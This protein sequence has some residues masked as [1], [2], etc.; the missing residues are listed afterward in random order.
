MARPTNEKP[1]LTTFCRGNNTIQAVYIRYNYK[2]VRHQGIRVADVSIDPTH[3]GKDGFVKTGNPD[4]QQHNRLIEETIDHIT[5]AHNT[6]VAKG[7]DF[8][9]VSLAA[10]VAKLQD[11]TRAAKAAAVAEEAEIARKQRFDSTLDSAIGIVEV[12]SIPDDENA[13]EKLERELAKKK[14]ELSALKKK[15]NIHKGDQLTVWLHN[16]MKRN[17]EGTT[18]SAST[19]R[20]N[21]SFINTVALFDKDA[22]IGDVDDQ[23]LLKFQQWMNTTPSITPIYKSIVNPATGKRENG[24]LLRYNTGRVRSNDTVENYVTKIKSMLNYYDAYSDLLPEGVTINQKYKRYKF[25]LQKKNDQVFPL[26]EAEILEIMQ[27]EGFTRSKER[28]RLMLLFLCSTGLRFSDGSTITK[29]DIEDGYINKYTQKGKKQG[30]QVYI[31]LNPVSE[32]VLKRCN[33]DLTSI[34]MEDDDTNRCI[35]EICKA[36]PSMHKKVTIV[37]PIGGEEIKVTKWK[38]DAITTHCGR[39]SH[40]NILLDYN[41][42]LPQVMS[43]T[44][45]SNL[46]TLQGYVDTRK[47]KVVEHTLNIFNL[48]TYTKSH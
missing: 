31:P 5:E 43:I 19:I 42:P 38:Y 28:A 45:H 39:R 9:A 24:D 35:A 13:I 20:T 2:G 40:I 3:L 30:I 23:W 21:T 33:Y 14:R 17:G 18:L 12:E 22:R 6:L 44:G 8:T 47:K 46:K 4:Y 27:M 29:D 25:T 36:L 11:D 15:H 37:T 41:T 26:T 34:A 7:T 32:Y 48:P 1:T 10:L 16:Y